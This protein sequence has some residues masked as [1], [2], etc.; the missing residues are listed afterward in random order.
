[1]MLKQPNSMFFIQETPAKVLSLLGT[2]MFSMFLLFGVT[3]TNASFE[4][5][6]N[7]MPDVFS[8]ANVT[9]MLDNVSSGYSNF[10][11]QTL[12]VPLQ[13]DYALAQDN[14]AFIID[15]AG[16]SILAFTG[17]EGLA[18]YDRENSVTPQ[19]AGAYTEPVYYEPIASESFS[20]DL[21]YN[22]L[23]GEY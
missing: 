5:T 15:E 12:L 4:R 8:P 20:V 3:F 17:L 1:L 14:I 18:Q 10:V 9:A 7:I 19:V 11:Q 2:A 22:V 16:P 21:I 13:Q 6:E 23:I